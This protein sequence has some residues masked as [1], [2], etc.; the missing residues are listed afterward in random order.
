[1][2]TYTIDEVAGILKVHSQMVRKLIKNGEL[3]TYRVGNTH[4]ITQEQIKEYLGNHKNK[5]D[6]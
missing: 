2:Q 6:R 4:R 1:M 3:Q 5:E